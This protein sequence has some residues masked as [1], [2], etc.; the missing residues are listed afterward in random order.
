MHY[1]RSSGSTRRKPRADEVGEGSSLTN[2]RRAEGRKWGLPSLGCCR[3]S[4]WADASPNG[5]ARGLRGCLSGFAESC[6]LDGLPRLGGIAMLVGVCLATSSYAQTALTWQQVKAR[7]RAANPA[8]QAAEIS[9]DESRAQEVTAYLRPNPGLSILTDGT[10]IAPFQGVWQPFLGTLYSSSVSYLHERAHKRELR[11][12]S[13][14]RATAITQLQYADLERTLLF[15]LR[16]AFIQTLQAKSVLELAKENLDYFDKQL[17][18]AQDRLKAGDIARVDLDR[19]ELQRVQYESDYQTAQVNLRTAKIQLLTLLND[20]TP[21]DQFDVTGPF[22]FSDQLPP[23]DEF[24]NLALATRPDLKAAVEAVDK[25]NTDHRLAIANGSTDPTFSTWWTHNSSTSNP[26]SQETLGA[27]ISVPLRIFDRNQGEK[28][29]TRLDISHA[30]RLR[31]A[32]LAQIYSDVDSSHATLVSTINLLRPYKDKY[33]PTVSRVRDTVSF[34]YQQGGVALVDYLDA[35]RDYRA[36]Q[37]SY[38]NLIASY[39][40]AANQLNLAVGREVLP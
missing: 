21:V 20:R 9:I 13:A 14:Q 8:L 15:N 22:D 27:S 11:L 17:S 24:R 39:L 4:S 31:D 32:N 35:Q 25:A 30:E 18:I 19:I 12:A 6:H 23:R 2:Q 29:R 1:L 40:T 36:V 33:L 10:Q 3:S 37:L 5:V 34:A 38:I 26:L 7:L 28:E 16:T